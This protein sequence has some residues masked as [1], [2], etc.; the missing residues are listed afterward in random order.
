[1]KFEDDLR[2]ALR[3]GEAP[4]DLEARVLARIADAQARVTARQRIAPPARAR[5]VMSW[6]ALAASLV[7]AA[8]GAFYFE[9]QRTQVEG[10]RA[11]REVV[12]AL[13]IASDKLALVQR[14]VQQSSQ[15][16]SESRR[17]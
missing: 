1:M 16:N 10:T 14:R 6:V 8:S 12:Q 17:P 4:D 5:R 13:Q 3:A 9:Q 15:S 2:R 7:V 11:A